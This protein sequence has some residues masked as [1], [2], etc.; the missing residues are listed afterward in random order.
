MVVVFLCHYNIIY[1]VILLTKKQLKSMSN[2]LKSKRM[3]L[4]YTQE[5]VAELTNIS[6]SAYSKIEN[7][8][9]S[10]SLNT[11]I[12]ISIILD[13]SIDYLIFAKENAEKYDTDFSNIITLLHNADIKQVYYVC[14]LLL[15]LLSKMNE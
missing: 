2:K 13:I 9:Q 10:P 12:R 1:E 7:A 11:L 4:G 5:K 8:I 15:Q 3:Q 6:Y 14:D